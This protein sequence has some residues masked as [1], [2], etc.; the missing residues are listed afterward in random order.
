MT[1]LLAHA[2]EVDGYS[3]CTLWTEA[4]WILSPFSKGGCPLLTLGCVLSRISCVKLLVSSLFTSSSGSPLP[5]KRKHSSRRALYLSLTALE[6]RHLAITQ[7][8]SDVE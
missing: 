3:R 7:Q 8:T 6:V 1:P 2:T 4:L 5:C